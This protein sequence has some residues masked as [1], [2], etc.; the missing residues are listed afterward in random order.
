MTTDPLDAL[1]DRSAPDSRRL[2]TEDARA[3][4]AASRA[5]VRVP[6][7]GRHRALLAGALAV[8][9]MGG[10]G[11]AVASGEWTWGEGLGSADRVYAY[12]SPTWGQC[13]L[14]F[15]ALDT[16][17]FIKNA[18]VNRI[19]DDWFARTDVEAAAAPLVPRFIAELEHAEGSGP[20][21]PTDPRSA[22]LNAWM[23]HEQAVGELIHEE[24]AANGF[25]VDDLQGA[26]SHSQVH[27]EDE[28]WGGE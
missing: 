9:F 24:L 28:D 15:S 8:L 17:D 10:A 4:I 2:K 3:M 22:D 13:E 18:Q 16:S 23:A 14:R 12:T 27:C 19:V 11:V 5:H 26:N 25:D 20:E 21:G 1:L 6:R 7:R